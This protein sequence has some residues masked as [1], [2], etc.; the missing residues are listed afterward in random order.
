VLQVDVLPDG[1]EVVA[2]VKSAGGLDAGKDAHG[3]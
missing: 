3:G 2:P 1:S